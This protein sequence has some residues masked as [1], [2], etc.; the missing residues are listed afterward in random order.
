MY[1]APMRILDDSFNLYFIDAKME[2]SNFKSRFVVSFSVFLLI[3]KEA[4][5][6]ILSVTTI[7]CAK[8]SF[9]VGKTALI[10]TVLPS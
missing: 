1:L 7:S 6:S 10:F 3:P 5:A 8:S 2:S 4:D 9:L